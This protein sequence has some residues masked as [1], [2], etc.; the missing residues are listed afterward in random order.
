MASRRRAPGRRISRQPAAACG[1]WPAEERGW[2][3]TELP[4]ES[5]PEENPSPRAASLPPEWGERFAARHCQAVCATLRIRHTFRGCLYP[6][7]PVASGTP[8]PAR[9][10]QAAGVGLRAVPTDPQSWLSTAS[11][12]CSPSIHPHHR[13]PGLRLLID[14]V[15]RFPAQTAVPG[16]SSKARVAS[17]S[18]PAEWPFRN[19]SQAL[20]SQISA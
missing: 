17:S 4:S 12:P 18:N 8:S 5:D 14:S 15:R 11:G 1:N 9:G 10:W 13:R 2:P 16:H 19:S 6:L 20:R 7:S 3:E